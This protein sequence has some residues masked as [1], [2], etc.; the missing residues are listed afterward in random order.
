MRHALDKRSEALA[1]LAVGLM[2][3]GVS[4]GRNRSTSADYPADLTCPS[5]NQTL[6]TVGRF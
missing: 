3:A 1:L 5:P 2:H 4:C 6:W